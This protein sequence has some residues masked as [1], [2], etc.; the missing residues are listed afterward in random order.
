M[1]EIDNMSKLKLSIA[2]W[3]YDRTRPLIDGAVGIEGV[4][5]KYVP[6][7]VEETFYRMLQNSEFDVAEMSLSGYTLTR[8]EDNPRF[9]AIPVFPSRTFRQRSIY[10]N[11]DSGI[12][13]PKDLIGKK[14]GLTRY[15]QTAGVYIRGMLAEDYGV[16]VESVKYVAGGLEVPEEDGKFWSMGSLGKK[17]KEKHGIDFSAESKRPLSPMLES[18]EIDAI[19][20]ARTPSSYNN[21]NGKVKRLFENYREEEMNYYR[22]TGIFPIMHTMVIKREVYEE[23]PWVAVNLYKAF[24]RAKALAYRKNLQTGALRYMLPWMNE[25]IEI[26]NELAG[27]D[28]WPYGIEPN[29][30]VLSAFLRYSYNQH[31]AKELL[32]PE[33]LFAKETH[34]MLHIDEFSPASL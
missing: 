9:I 1:G 3:D 7:W 33:D 10:V 25:E 24:V 14:V 2:F 31:L 18:G 32:K 12:E 19:Y 23:N 15:R 8:F 11:K 20:T 5:A 29:R 6:L 34:N 28:Y 27:R 21:G 22:K 30:T 17:L 13:S 4:E 16:P 26:M